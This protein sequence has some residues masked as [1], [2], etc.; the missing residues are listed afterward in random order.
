VPTFFNNVFFSYVVSNKGFT[1]SP[2]CPDA[3]LWVVSFPWWVL[4]TQCVNSGFH[5]FLFDTHCANILELRLKATLCGQ[6]MLF[7]IGGYADSLEIPSF[8]PVISKSRLTNQLFFVKFTLAL[9]DKE[10]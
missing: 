2:S 10:C 6:S 7:F 5:T 3:W 1:Y 9:N 8:F 4:L